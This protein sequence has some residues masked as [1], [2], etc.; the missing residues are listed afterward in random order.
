MQPSTGDGRWERE[1]KL[2]DDDGYPRRPGTVVA[3]ATVDAR[4]AP[5]ARVREGGRRDFGAAGGACSSVVPRP[6][7]AS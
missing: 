5:G 2:Q 3:N 7:V 6:T 4:R 1:S